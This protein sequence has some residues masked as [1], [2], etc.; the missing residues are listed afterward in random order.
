MKRV[1]SV[2]LR[3]YV[4]WMPVLGADDRASAARLAARERDRRARHFWA[5]SRAFGQAWGRPHPP[6]DGPLAWDV[7]M[8]FDRG[9]RWGRG[10]LPEPRLVRYPAGMNPEGQPAFDA[11]ELRAAVEGALAAAGR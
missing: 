11:A 5:P 9:V 4:V 1:A 2:D 6:S 3:A 8:L 7:V 10:A